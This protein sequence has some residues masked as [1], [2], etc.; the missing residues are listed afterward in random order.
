MLANAIQQCGGEQ[1]LYE[2]IMGTLGYKN[3][4][5]PFRQLARLVTLPVLLEHDAVCDAYATLLGVSSLLP[6]TL[7]DTWEDASRD[8]VRS[9]WDSWWKRKSGW[10]KRIMP[11]AAWHLAGLRP[12]NHPIRR[13]VAAAELFSREASLA[14]G[15]LACDTESPVAW[16]REIGELLE[17]DVTTP[18]WEKRLGFGGHSGDSPIAIVG[19]RRRA[20]IISNVIVPFVAARGLDV[21][22]LLPRLPAEE[23]NQFI[24]QTAHLL[25][26]PD[27]NPAF[28]DGGVL[29]QGLIQIFHDFCLPNRLN[30]MAGFFCQPRDVTTSF[31]SRA[32]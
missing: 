15:I 19:S 9:L 32:P 3:N 1:A 13:L 14:D 27:H 4:R 16:F 2:A 30:E 21:R 22:P 26:G 25:F 12:H 31:A 18:Y 20:A 29:Q 6:E 8:F 23:S 10:E 17:P 11:R 5:V 28:Y 7:E 24:R